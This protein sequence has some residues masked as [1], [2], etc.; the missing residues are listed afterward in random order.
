MTYELKA[1][2]AKV[3]ELK[4]RLET[5]ARH[6]GQVDRQLER[7]VGSPTNRPGGGTQQEPAWPRM[8]PARGGV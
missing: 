2:R 8:P 7:L 1:L 4:D 3:Q 5:L 6:S